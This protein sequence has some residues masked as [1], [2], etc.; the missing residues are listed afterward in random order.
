[1]AEDVARESFERSVKR[2]QSRLADCNQSERIYNISVIMTALQLRCRNSL[3][4]IRDSGSQLFNS[5][6][7]SCSNECDVWHQNGDY[8]SS[9]PNR[10]LQKPE[11]DLNHYGRS[12]E[13]VLKI[14]PMTVS[15]QS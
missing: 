8:Y 14:A 5:S 15:V 4:N 12:K 10:G 3:N 11:L 9:F 2:D 1:M 13:E 6:V 7:C